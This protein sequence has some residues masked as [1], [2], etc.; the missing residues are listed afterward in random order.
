M[1][2]RIPSSMTAK[3]LQAW[4]KRHAHSLTDGSAALGVSRS[5]FAE[6]L[7]GTLPIPY[8]VQLAAAYWDLR[9]RVQRAQRLPES[10][11][12]PGKG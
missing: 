2:P 1:A 4:K 12:N 5:M 11:G 3:Q 9:Q 6:Y 10:Q 8:T 7:A